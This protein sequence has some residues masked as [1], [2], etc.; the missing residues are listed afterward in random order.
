VPVL[1]VVPQCIML[2]GPGLV[3]KSVQLLIVSSNLIASPWSCVDQVRRFVRYFEW[4]TVFG[5]SKEDQGDA[6]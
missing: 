4:L 6:N 3:S 5:N 1:K 2:S